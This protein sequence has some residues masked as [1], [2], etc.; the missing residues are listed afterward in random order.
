MTI[1]TLTNDQKNL[2]AKLASEG[3]VALAEFRNDKPEIVEYVDKKSGYKR[4]IAKHNFA[5]E[6]LGTS[7]QCPAELYT[8]RS[9]E[10]R[11]DKDGLAIEDQPLPE[12][13][14]KLNLKKGAALIVGI[15]SYFAKAGVVK[16]KIAKIYVLETLQEL[17]LKPEDETEKPSYQLGGKGLKK[18]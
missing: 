18:A 16:C 13:P 4:Y 7:D 1:D 17:N 6:F 12:L 8:A 2:I 10:P 5:M 3:I 9:A 15:G 14:Q 11:T